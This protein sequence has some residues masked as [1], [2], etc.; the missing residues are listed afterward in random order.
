MAEGHHQGPRFGTS[1]WGRRS[2]TTNSLPLRET[3]KWACIC[4]C[5][6]GLPAS[7]LGLKMA[8]RVLTPTNRRDKRQRIVAIEPQPKQPPH[9]GGGYEHSNR[10]TAANA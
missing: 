8:V 2:A 5:F 10:V 4:W 3:P 9:A 1:W 7:F 6:R